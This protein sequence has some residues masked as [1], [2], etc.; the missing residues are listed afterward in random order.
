MVMYHQTMY[1]SKT[2]NSSE[3]TVETYIFCFYK[4]SLWSR[5]KQTNLLNDT[6]ADNDASPYQVWLQK[7]SSLEDTVGANIHWSI[8]DGYLLLFWRTPLVDCSRGLHCLSSLIQ[9]DWLVI[10]FT[11]SFFLCYRIQLLTNLWYH[12]V[13]LDSMISAQTEKQ[14]VQPPSLHSWI[15]RI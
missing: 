7:L 1:G 8:A 13:F 9:P 4:P 12:F 3:D 11:K 5:R 15:V 2:I 6:L 14:V 10:Y